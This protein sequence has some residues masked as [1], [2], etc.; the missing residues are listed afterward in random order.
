LEALLRVLADRRQHR[1]AVSSRAHEAVAGEGLEQSV[2]RV[3]DLLRRRQRPAVGEDAQAGE[4]LLLSIR[5]QVVRPVDRGAERAVPGV[6]VTSS[7]ARVE[8]AREALQEELRR[9][10][11]RTGCG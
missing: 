11:A 10:Q 8:T 3:A 4:Q 9:E 6:D 2:V 5:Q 7:G 1:E